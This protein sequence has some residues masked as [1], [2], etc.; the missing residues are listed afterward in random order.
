MAAAGLLFY[1]LV[2]VVMNMGA[3]AVVMSV[4]RQGEENLHLDD[5]AGL[6][7]RE[8]MLGV[9]LTIFLL[10][11]AGF[12]GT[13]GFMGKIYLL[14]GA[15]E[16]HLWTLAIIL[17]LTTV[18]SYYYYLRVAWYMWMRAP[19]REDQHEGLVVPFPVRVALFA[20]V[21]VVLLLGVFPS[22]LMDLARGSV[23]ALS[24]VGGFVLGLAP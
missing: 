22:A 16:A 21:A 11:L 13:A 4:G 1:L 23:G 15:A 5:Y 10:S 24:G 6:G 19:A 7:G 17:V 12:P 3:F 2:Y 20:G 8:P 14:Q 18:V 9:F